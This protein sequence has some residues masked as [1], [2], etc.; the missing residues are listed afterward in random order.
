MNGY[1]SRGNNSASFIFASLLNWD[2]FLKENIC[3]RRSKFFP[4]KSRSHSERA[5]LSRETNRKSQKFF[6]FLKMIVKHGGVP[7][8]NSFAWSHF[9][10]HYCYAYNVNA[11]AWSY[12]IC[13]HYCYAKDVIFPN[14]VWWCILMNKTCHRE[15]TAHLTA[16]C[17]SH[18]KL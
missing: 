11:F 12:F 4:F 3:S 13:L 1:S 9:C 16:P 6:P 10:L 15:R 5:I 8:L 18:K 14:W 17:P 2:Q 7:K